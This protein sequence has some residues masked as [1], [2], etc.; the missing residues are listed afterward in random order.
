MGIGLG[1]AQRNW[2]TMGFECGDQWR[3]RCGSGA[4]GVGGIEKGLGAKVIYCQGDVA[5]PEDR[6]RM[7]EEVRT[8][9]GA[10]HVLVNNAG[11]APKERRDIL[12]A[13][14]ESFDRVVSTNPQGH[15]LSSRS[16]LPIG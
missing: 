6:K 9:F 12:E 10:L 8:H 4:G 1:I 3:A 11:V 16:W 15:L 2:L 13:T 7:I 5:G 14:E